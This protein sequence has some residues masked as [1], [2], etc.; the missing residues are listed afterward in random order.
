MNYI[1]NLIKETVNTNWKDILLSENNIENHKLDKAY[2]KLG[3]LLQKESG[4]YLPE[5]DKIFRAFNYFDIQDTKVIIIGADPYPG[6]HTSNSGQKIPY[7]CGLAFSY[8]EGIDKAKYSLKNI[9]KELE[10][11]YG[12]LR[13]NTN[14]EDWAKQGVL[15]INTSLTVRKHKSN[16][17][18]NKGWERIIDFILMALIKF[19][20]NAV[21][22]LLGKSAQSKAHIIYS[23]KKVPNI[24]IAGHPSPLNRTGGFIGSGC[25]SFVNEELKNNE[26]EPIKWL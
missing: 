22:L 23:R 2:E 21:Y 24:I 4:M 8:S 18:T 6:Y 10:H 9:F 15:L 20:P 16:S 7:A 14:L 13:K 19:A 25:F 5:E 1:I 26:M 17:H 3:I 12:S 11:E